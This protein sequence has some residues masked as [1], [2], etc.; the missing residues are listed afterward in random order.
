MPPTQGFRED[1]SRETGDPSKTGQPARLPFKQ[2]HAGSQRPEVQ[3]APPTKQ[4]LIQNW[5]DSTNAFG[6]GGYRAKAGPS[7]KDASEEPQRPR[8]TLAETLGPDEREEKDEPTEL[9]KKNK[10]KK[11]VRTAGL[12]P[13]NTAV[14]Q[15]LDPERSDS[16]QIQEA[17]L[18]DDGSERRTIQRRKLWYILPVQ[19]ETELSEMDKVNRDRESEA[20]EQLKNS[21]NPAGRI[22]ATRAFER[23][24]AEARDKYERYE[25]KA[26]KDFREF[27]KECEV[28]AADN[29]K[30][31]ND[32]KN[33]TTQLTT[34]MRNGPNSKGAAEI[35]GHA[36]ELYNN[37]IQ[38]LENLEKGESRLL[39]EKDNEMTRIFLEARFPY[40]KR[41]IEMHHV[42]EEKRK[43]TYYHT[44]KALDVTKKA[45][46]ELSRICADLSPNM[47]DW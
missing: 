38:T 6:T 44:L 41:S 32:F 2:I 18:S 36:E 7:R 17:N 24:E 3:S 35:S 23:Y 26:N 15:S 9:R 10:G 13:E 4:K 34:V 29:W 11:P 19:R 43:L 28:E 37:A 42:D 5:A 39:N 16:Q 22:F 12:E 31:L 14:G 30:N 27:L 21:K 8:S 1:K 40:L 20:Q 45:V 47:G 46:G 33:L 25:D